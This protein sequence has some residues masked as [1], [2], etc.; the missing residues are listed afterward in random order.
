[1]RAKDVAE[2]FLSLS[3]P[4]CEDFISNLK[5]QKL[6][7]YAQGFH[8]AI[9]GEPLFDEPIEAWTHGPVVKDLYHEYKEHG[10]NAIDKPV[11]IDLNRYTK[12]IRELL[13]DVWK[14]YGQY[15]ASK[16]RN[17]THAEPIWIEAYNK[18]PGCVISHDS[19]KKYFKTLLFAS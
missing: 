4:E 5:L 2:Y 15:S 9:F 1:M 10:A 13:D 14:V 19:M 3:D 6:V 11:S 7:Y 17:L 16:L 18:Y 12:D 8:L